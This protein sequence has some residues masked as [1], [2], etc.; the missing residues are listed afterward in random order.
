MA[1]DQEYQGDPSQAL[2]PVDQQTITFYG[3]PLVVVRLP[4]GRAGAVLRWFCDNL[5]LDRSGQ[6]RRIQRTAA[7]ADDLL[8]V[9]VQTSSGVQV[10]PTLVLRGVPFWLAGID[11]KRVREEV[12]TEVLRY[13]REVVDVLYAWAQTP[14]VGSTAVVPAEPVAE[15]VRPADDA[16]LA[17]WREYYLRM[18][19][20]IEWQMDVEVWRG[21]VETRLEGLE[22]VTDLIPEILDR[23]GPQTITPAHQNRCKYLVSQLSQ[24]SG[25]HPATIYSALYTAFSVPRYQELPEE[26]WPQVEQWF[27]RQI[28]R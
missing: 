2:V 12:R 18:A 28:K 6:V 1:E 5:H 22:A 13:Q 26:E 15:P 9:Q 23:L 8:Y 7:I 21:T 10:M 17:D 25:A 16:A 24:A 20:V 19:A 4:D 27:A 11:P 14:R 3:Q